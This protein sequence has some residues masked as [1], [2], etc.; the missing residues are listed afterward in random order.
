MKIPSRLRRGAAMLSVILFALSGCGAKRAGSVPAPA[1]QTPA[2]AG[3]FEIP[4]FRGA[5]FHQA[6]A[7]DF[8]NI[9]LDASAL[10][11]GV[12]A[13]R[14]VSDSRMK[15]QIVCGETKYNYDLLSGEPAVLPLNMGNGS[16]TFR[17]MEQVVESKYACTWSETRDV[18]MEDEFQTF[19]RPSQL[20]SYDRDSLCVAKARELAA[21]CGTDAEVASAIY[22]YLVDNIRYDRKKAAT[23]QSGYLPD[24]DETLATGK[25]ICFDY[26]SLAAAMM[27]S[28]G[29][30]CKLI[31]GYVG[32]D[33]YHAWNSFYLQDQGWV[34]VEIRAAPNSWQ[35]VDITFAAGGTP[36]DALMDDSRYTTRYTY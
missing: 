36:A 13:L 2:A 15:L 31:T 25:G 16:Y 9:Q 23:V 10:E 29:I 26:A 6:L 35:R 19:L 24:P 3:Q 14:A 8:G 32:Q 30:P 12:V 18:T 4:E 5:E 34:T 20:V 27:R 17:L 22:G 21:S 28:L 1:A 7:E 11:Q 33:T